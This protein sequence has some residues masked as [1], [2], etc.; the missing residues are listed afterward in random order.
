MVDGDTH[1]TPERTKRRGCS[2][3][4]RYLS[5]LFTRP[6][7]RAFVAQSGKN[8]SQTKGFFGGEAAAGATPPG[9]EKNPPDTE[10]VGRF[11]CGCA[12]ARDNMPGA[13]ARHQ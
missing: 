10:G 12:Y 9:N 13:E 11:R 3:H 5:K 6:G 7:S 8:P 2:D 1:R 4:D